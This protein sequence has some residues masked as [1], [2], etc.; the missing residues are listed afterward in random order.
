MTPST[1]AMIPQPVCSTATKRSP[2]MSKPQSSNHKIAAVDLF[3]GAGGLT[4]GL[5]KAGISVV[6][7]IDLDPACEFPFEANNKSKFILRDVA[8][9]TKAD[10]LNVYP[11]SATRIL[12]GCAPCQPFSRYS[13]AVVRTGDQKWAMLEQFAR[14]ITDIQPAVISMENVPELARHDVFRNFVQRLKDCGYHVSSN[15]VFC[16]DYGVPQHRTR[17]VLFASLSGA[18][19]LIPPTHRP[20]NYRT[21]KQAISKLSALSPGEIDAEDC[22]HRVSHLSDLNLRRIRASKQGGCWRDWPPQLVAKCHQKKSGETFPSVYGRME[23]DSPAPT[24]TTQFFGYG[25]GRFGH[26]EQDRAISLREGAILQSFPRKYRFCRKSA[27]V[28]FAT[29]GRLIGN[30]VPVRLGEII[31]KTILHHIAESNGKKN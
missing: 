9:V 29:L 31:G 17:L 3:C 21:V 16:P 11:K 8:E 26:P 20:D 19:A 25:N 15:N 4:H 12:V 6:A 30:A 22:L 13:Q 24:I 18:V 23:W 7:G 10:L 27:D 28:S 5:V 14:L 1:D 2:Q